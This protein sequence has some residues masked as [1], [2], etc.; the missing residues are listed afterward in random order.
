MRKT[1]LFAF[2]I[3]LSA[4]SFAQ[5]QKEI[6]PKAIMVMNDGSEKNVY[7]V[8]YNYPIKPALK[9]FRKTDILNFEVKLSPEAETEKINSDLVKAVKFVDDYDDE[10][11]GLEKLKMKT[12]D[13][14][15]KISD[16]S[17]VSWQPLL[18][19]GKIKIYG[20][21]SYMCAQDGNQC[22]YA[23][24]EFFLRNSQDDYAVMPVDYDRLNLLNFW[25]ADERMIESFKLV[26]KNC[27]NFNSYVDTVYQ[28]F[29][30]KNFRKKMSADIK[31]ARKR[32]FDE[33]KAENLGYNRT[34]ERVGRR[35]QEYYMNFYVGIIQEYEKNCK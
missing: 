2:F 25:K 33:G 21:N 29:Q 17:H 26:G 10:I 13:S 9:F 11:L 14:D 7:F 30:D 18:Y 20:S 19:D 15:G 34:Q 5:K 12:V 24:S 22:S 6:Y 27:A 23:V 16:K 32:G 31:E 4:A 3:L 28:K 8:A 1:L 35:T